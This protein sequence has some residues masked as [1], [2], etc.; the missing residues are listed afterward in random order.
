ME[1]VMMDVMFEIPSDETIEKV[2]ITKDS[3]LGNS[4]PTVIRFGESTQ[5]K[6]KRA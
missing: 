6:K 5:S 3:V 2:I 4:K 1:K